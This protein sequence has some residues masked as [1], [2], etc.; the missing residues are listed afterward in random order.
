MRQTE[1]RTRKGWM[2]RT[3]AF[4]QY[5]LF[6]HP[7]SLSHTLPNHHAAFT[8]I[9]LMDSTVPVEAMVGM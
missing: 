4:R 7:I 8:R 1:P 3:L 5:L 2:V 9:G 6:R